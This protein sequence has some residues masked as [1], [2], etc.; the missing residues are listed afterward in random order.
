MASLPW[1]TLV[2]HGRDFIHKLLICFYK[3]DPLRYFQIAILIFLLFQLLGKTTIKNI[4][5]QI[6]ILFS[7]DYLSARFRRENDK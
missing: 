4:F 1:H 2:C 6:F 5:R 7:I 3:L